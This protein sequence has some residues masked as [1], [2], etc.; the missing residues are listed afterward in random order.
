MYVGFC[1]SIHVTSNVELRRAYLRNSYH[2]RLLLNVELRNYVIS[3]QNFL[4]NNPLN[5]PGVGWVNFFLGE[6]HSRIYPHMRAKFCRGP[7]VVSKQGGGEYRHS[8]YE[9]YTSMSGT[10]RPTMCQIVVL[11]H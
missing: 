11:I 4:S 3:R 1:V 9:T 5:P 6:S 8:N 2:V 10:I 7:T